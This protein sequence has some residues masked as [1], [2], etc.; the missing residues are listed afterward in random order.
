MF[1]DVRPDTYCIDVD[2]AAAA[3][4]PRT[5]G[6]MPVHLG[7]GMSD[8][9]AVMALADR[10]GLFVIEDCAHAHGAA[11]RGRGAGSIGTAGSFSMQ[12]GKLMTAGEG[13]AILTS[14]DSVFDDVSWRTRTAAG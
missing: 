2:A 8:M 6:I 3:I 4:T 1:V 12:T 9:D 13:G 5:R 10:H 14:D 11:W 7:M